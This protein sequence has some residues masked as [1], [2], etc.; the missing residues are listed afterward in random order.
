MRRQLH[1]DAMM[2]LAVRALAGGARHRVASDDATFLC[3]LE[4]DIAGD[5]QKPVTVEVYGRPSVHGQKYVVIGTKGPTVMGITMQTQC[6]NCP[7]CLKRRAA[8]W[9]LRALTEWRQ[10]PRTWLVT[11][12]FRPEVHIQ[13]VSQCR[14]NMARQGIDYDALPSD[15]DRFRQLNI[16]TGHHV[17]TYLKR[18]RKEG[19]RLRY[20]AVAEA[21]KSGL[22]HYHMLMHEVTADKPLLHAAITKQWVA[23]F[24]NAKLVHDQ[25]GA[26]YAAKY[27]AKTK[28]ARVRASVGYGSPRPQSIANGHS[29]ALSVKNRPLNKQVFSTE[30]NGVKE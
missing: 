4:W 21:H 5:C 7:N 19:A 28:L 16:V 30:L 17:T 29:E 18:L 27:L 13:A 2:R 10:A 6:R 24:I 12:T 26:T 14:L 3:H 20:M 25:L 23:G 1:H 22:T 11:L 8:H 9:R 15:E